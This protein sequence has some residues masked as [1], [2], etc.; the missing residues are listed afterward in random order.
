MREEFQSSLQLHIHLF[1][2]DNH[3]IGTRAL[4]ECKR[5]FSCALD[6]HKEYIGDFP[7]VAMPVKEGSIISV[8]GIP[9]IFSSS[10]GIFAKHI[11]VFTSRQIHKRDVMQRG[12]NVNGRIKK[13]YYSQ[14]ESLAIVGGDKRITKAISN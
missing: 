4:N 9:T 1:E 2:D 14:K 8:L 12:E 6:S 13:G 5:Q 11:I 10:D 3:Y 7:I